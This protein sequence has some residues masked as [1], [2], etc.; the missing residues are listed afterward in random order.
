MHLSRDSQAASWGLVGVLSRTSVKHFLEKVWKMLGK[1]LLSILN[2]AKSRS[3]SC[4]G[5]DLLRNSVKY[6][7]YRWQPHLA[8]NTAA[9]RCTSA[10]PVNDLGLER[11]LGGI[12]VQKTFSVFEW[13]LL[14]D[15]F[16]SSCVLPG[17]HWFSTWFEYLFSTWFE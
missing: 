15:S 3:V 14:V 2:S 5:T 13:L 16:I 1:I 9:N 6:V 10:C 17:S 7:A 12:C 11:N 8:Q 4:T